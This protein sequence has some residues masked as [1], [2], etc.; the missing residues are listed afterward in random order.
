MRAAREVSSISRTP[1]ELVHVYRNH[2]AGFRGRN[3]PDDRR[4]AAERDDDVSVPVAPLQDAL[5]LR[6]VARVRHHVRRV[7]KTPLDSR[8]FAVVRAVRVKRALVVVNATERSD[9][10]RR[11][12]PG[13]AQVEIVGAR[14]R[15]GDDL[16]A[17]SLR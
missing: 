7:G 8:R 16:R 6:I 13:R 5:Q 15:R 3:A 17:E 12:Y 14:Y 11:G 9:R 1:I 2:R 10:V 4:P